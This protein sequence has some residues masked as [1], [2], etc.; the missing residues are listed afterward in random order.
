MIRIRDN[1]YPSRS[2]YVI[3]HYIQFENHES[4]VNQKEAEE[5]LKNRDFELLK[6][7]PVKNNGIEETVLNGIRVDKKKRLLLGCVEFSS[8]TGMPMYILYLTKGLLE[9]GWDVDIVASRIGG[10]PT[11]KARE[12]GAGVFTFEEEGYLDN[13]YE[14]LI[15][16]EPQSECLYEKFPKVSAIN[17]VHSKYDCEKPHAYRP[18]IRQYLACR[19]DVVDYW[20]FSFEGKWEV[21]NNPIDFD[22]FKDK[23]KIKNKK[24]TILSASTLDPLRKPMLLDLIKR[25]EDENVEVIIKGKDYHALDDVVLPDN[26][27]VLDESEDIEK[28]IEMADE[29]AGIYMGRIT[30]EAMAMGKK[31]LVYD[32][33]GSCVKGVVPENFRKEYDYKNVAQRLTDIINRKWADIIIPHHNKHDLLS[34]CLKC[35]SLRN[36]NIIVVAGTHFSDAINKGVRIAETDN[37]IFLNDDTEFSPDIL[38]KLL[39]D[40]KDIVGV[41]QKRGDDSLLCYGMGWRLETRVPF[42]IVFE[43]D[44]VMFPSGAM[45]RIKKDLFLTLGGL[46]TRYINGMEDVDLFVKAK[47]QGCSMGIIDDFIKHHEGQSNGRYRYVEYNE[48]LFNKMYSLDYLTK[49]FP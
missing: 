25:A 44:Q 39:D 9:L 22:K 37:L 36:Y 5:L 8:L 4:F 35:I 12:L 29:V 13:E 48:K 26:V 47:E 11:D 3:D 7:E 38:W 43:K 34:N 16:S 14:F 45:I 17:L 20:K 33:D 24:Y 18:Q 28:D 41:P 40:K 49:L 30:L 21:L 15:L 32:V 10:I 1:K 27:K 42:G 23:K 31:T 2:I 6:E 46:D 19:Q